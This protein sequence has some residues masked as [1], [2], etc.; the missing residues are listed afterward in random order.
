LLLVQRDRQA[1]KETADVKIG[2]LMCA[3]DS[4]AYRYKVIDKSV[5]SKQ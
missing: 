1:Q 2:R 3:K 5:C 4:D